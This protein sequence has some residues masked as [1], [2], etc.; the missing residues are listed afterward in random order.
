MIWLHVSNFTIHENSKAHSLVGPLKNSPQALKPT[1]IMSWANSY[2]QKGQLTPKMDTKEYRRSLILGAHPFQN[3]SFEAFNYVKKIII[4]Y[5]LIF[6]QIYFHNEGLTG[7]GRNLFT[8][9]HRFP[10][11]GVTYIYNSLCILYIHSY[12]V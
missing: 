7:A 5:P 8:T 12:I 2:I 1:W 11:S 6:F 9:M 4:K 3:S 10:F